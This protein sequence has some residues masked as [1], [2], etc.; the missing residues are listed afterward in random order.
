MDG[1]DDMD[2]AGIRTVKESGLQAR[3]D[4]GGVGTTE[5][6]WMVEKT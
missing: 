2:G 3:R 5:A 6:S 1:G 4:N